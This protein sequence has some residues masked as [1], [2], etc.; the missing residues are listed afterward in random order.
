MEQMEIQLRLSSSNRGAFFI[1]KDGVDVAKMEIGIAG[2]NMTVYHTE[3]SDVL[4]G[5]GVAGKLLEK[6]VEYARANQLKV[7]ALC[8]YVHAQF[9]KHPEQ[10]VDIWNQNWHTK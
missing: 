2:T 7:I 9:K 6:M 8:P 3:V 10:Y 5:Q 1:E 4:K